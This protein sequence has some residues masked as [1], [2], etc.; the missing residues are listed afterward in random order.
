MRTKPLIRA[1][2]AA[3]ALAFASGAALAE[4][5]KVGYLPVTGHAKF[6]VAKEQ[7]FFKQEGLDVELV[8]FVNSADGLNAVVAN[9][10]DIGAFGTTAPLVHYSRG[11][12]LKIIGGIMGE[13]AAI[14]VKP[15]NADKIRSVADLKGKKIATIRLATGDAVLRAALKDQ[16]I[17][18]KKDV[19]I[20]ELKSPPAVLEAVKSGQVDAGVTWGPHDIRA[21]RQGL[22]VVIRTG[23]L[24]PGHPC[25]RLVVKSERLKEG[26]TWDRFLRAILKAEKFAAQNRKETIDAIQKYVKLDRDILEQGY[27][28]PHLEQG[29]DPNVKGTQKFWTTMVSSEFIEGSRPLQPAFALDPYHR[30][31]QGLAKEQPNDPFWKQKLKAEQERNVL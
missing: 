16:K 30:A 20:F 10:L 2:L 31:L 25:C 24:Q 23:E 5:L 6:F 13:D 27:Y 18:W 26:D 22:K 19:E 28:S 21:E 1:G 29:T 15:E 4:S 17:D 7:G 9:K 8:E 11:A 14:I 3:L 12:D